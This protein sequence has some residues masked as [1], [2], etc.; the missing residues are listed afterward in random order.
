MYQTRTLL[1]ARL[2]RNIILVGAIL[3]ASQA[4]ADTTDWSLSAGGVYTSGSEGALSGSGIPTISVTGDGTL[5]D[6][7]SSLAIVDGFLNFTT[8]GYNGNG[9]NW[10]WTA[11]GV[12]NVTG[13]IPGVTASVCDGT[14][15]VAL[16]SD[17]FQSLQI[18]S[19]GGILDAVFGDITGTLNSQVAAYFGV[20]TQFET[21]SFTTTIAALGSPGT[22]L[23]GTNLSGTIK[24]VPGAT[25]VPERWT[26]FESLAFFGLALLL[27]AAL[28]RYSS[29]RLAPTQ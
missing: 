12:L 20:S 11:G 2:G 15:N 18:E 3:L 17:D 23:T 1:L 27:F 4:F 29:L 8:G 14:D 10:S 22:G 9:S 7:G 6:N 28:L 5:V 24:A 13:C 16:L 26:I 21:A 25:Q 19:V